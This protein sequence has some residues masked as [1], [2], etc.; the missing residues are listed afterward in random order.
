MIANSKQ[1]TC[2]T[3]AWTKTWSYLQSDVAFKRWP[4]F[5]ALVAA[6]TVTSLKWDASRHVE[7]FHLSRVLM[8]HIHQ[9]LHWLAHAL[10][11]H[12]VQGHC[13]ATRSTS[14]STIIIIIIYLSMLLLPFG[15]P[16][17][18]GGCGSWN[19]CIKKLKKYFW[20]WKSRI[21]ISSENLYI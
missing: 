1:N 12:L 16:C 10:C 7:V 13:C 2:Q 11:P 4:A 20:I 17:C 19:I 14:R 3:V 15:R 18:S 6:A 5:Q 9:L 8:L 21:W